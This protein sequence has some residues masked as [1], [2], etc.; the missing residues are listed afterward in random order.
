MSFDVTCIH[1]LMLLICTYFSTSLNRKKRLNRLLMLKIEM[2]MH[3][4][5]IKNL[6]K[7]SIVSLTVSD[8][9]IK[10]NIIKKIIKTM[11][12]T[13][14]MIAK[15]LMITS[16]RRQREINFLFLINIAWINIYRIKTVLTLLHSNNQ[17]FFIMNNILI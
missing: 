14:T 13:M 11:I 8:L 9:M 1:F 4:L 6:R 12:I 15:Y 16:H 7:A 5:K 17:N 2:F 3:R 10:I